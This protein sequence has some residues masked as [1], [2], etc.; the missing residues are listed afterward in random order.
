M[1]NNELQGMHNWIRFWTLE[2]KG[3][4][5]YK[6]YC[7]AL[8]KDDIRC[9][10]VRFGWKGE[11]KDV[12]TFLVG[13]SVAFEFAMYTIAFLGFAGSN[14]D[15]GDLYLGP[16]VGPIRITTYPWNTHMGNC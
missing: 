5:H 11:A 4:L 16:N 3:K 2:Q 6:G 13:T 9:V 15:K 14:C 8:T 1:G 10:S 12:S 7:G